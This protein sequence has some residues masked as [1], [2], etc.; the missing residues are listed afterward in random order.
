MTLAIG[1]STAEED[2]CFVGSSINDVPGMRSSVLGASVRNEMND[3]FVLIATEVVL[4]N[5]N[6]NTL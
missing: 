5:N 3:S 6:L 1:F 2:I 4:P